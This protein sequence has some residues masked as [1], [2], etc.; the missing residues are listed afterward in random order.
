MEHPLQG[1][2]VRL[3]LGKWMHI[4][5]LSTTLSHILLCFTFVVCC[6]FGS[7]AGVM[8]SLYCCRLGLSTSQA[9]DIIE[10]VHSSCRIREITVVGGPLATRGALPD[11]S[12]RLD[13]Y[14]NTYNKGY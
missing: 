4:G 11:G 7:M 13:V 14:H 12:S 9:S 1:I 5:V 8:F 3:V 6:T 2:S 10:R